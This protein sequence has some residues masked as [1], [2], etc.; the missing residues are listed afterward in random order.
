MQVSVETIGA[1]GRKLKVA[2]PAEELEKAFSARLKR[3]STQV[4]MPGFRPGKVPLKLVEAQYGD[5]LME[6]V[7]GDLIQTSFREVVTREG[8]RPAAGPRIQR[9]T[10]KRGAQLEYTA[11][12]EVL[13]DIK[14]TDLAGVKIERPVVAVEAA[15]VER[16]LE[17]IRKQRV[18]WQ[19]VERAAQSG[20]RVVMDFVGK[21]DGEAFE[22]G[23]A[24]DFP[25]V[26]GSQTLI[27]D[28]EK[29]LL[30]AKRGES[31]TVKATFPKDYRHPR[32]AGQAVTF[33]VTVKEVAE[34]VLPTVDEAFAKLLGVADGSLDTLRKEVQQNLEREAAGRS[35]NVV[36]AQVI[37]ALLEANKIELPTSLIE[38]EMNRLRQAE[39]V[40]RGKQPVRAPVPEE[41]WRQRARER[42]A[43]GLI[44]GEVMRARGIKADPARVRAKLEELAQEYDSPQ[45]FIQWHY[46]NPERLAD[47]E[48][49]VLEQRLVEEMMSTADASDKPMSFDELVK[50]DAAS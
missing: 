17:T 34:P 37:K 23:S 36:R 35:R 22:G 25:V 6:E 9:Q 4:R 47:V 31:R 44:V 50:M 12:F 24:N 11:D 15:D 43:V 1:L 41:A 5:S 45:E 14:R 13:P 49:L 10:V 2:L 21:I 32:L 30:D 7:A 19:P 3:L 48:S 40:A 8:L 46:Q 26:L 16:T 27:D 18:T 33:E 42:V 28:F 29:G 20:D 38:S 39:E